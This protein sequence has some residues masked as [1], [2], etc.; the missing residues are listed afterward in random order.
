[1]LLP[2]FK[3]P[4]A[5]ELVPLDALDL[6]PSFLFASLFFLESEGIS[7]DYLWV[8]Q[9]IAL[10]HIIECCRTDQR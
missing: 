4:D 8:G 3:L 7:S 9:L 5:E 2:F 1:M 10:E 6:A